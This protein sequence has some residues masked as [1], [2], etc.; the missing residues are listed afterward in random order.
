MSI[1]T[2]DDY[3]T[4][5]AAALKNE[6]HSE[7]WHKWLKMRHARENAEKYVIKE[8]SVNHPGLANYEILSKFSNYLDNNFPVPKFPYHC[9][10]NE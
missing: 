4:L 7:H 5:V 6:K 1:V 9:I 2:Y 3:I 8:A 10:D